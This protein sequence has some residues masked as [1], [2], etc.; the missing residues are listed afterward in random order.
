[1][2]E[3]Q[4]AALAQINAADDATLGAGGVSISTLRALARLGEIELTELEPV[5]AYGAL[6]PCGG[7]HR[8]YLSRRYTV[9][10]KNNV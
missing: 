5:R 2:T 3:T 9:R 7:R 6:G 4:R 1:M 10:H 8:G